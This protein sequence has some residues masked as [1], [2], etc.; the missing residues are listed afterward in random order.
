MA[1]W[2]H[3]LASAAA[4]IDLR[5]AMLSTLLIAH[6][7]VMSA[8]VVAWWLFLCAFALFNVTLWSRTALELERQKH[9]I[10]PALLAASRIQLR[11]SGVYVF[12]CAF[13][14]VLPVY[15]IPRICLFDTW[16]ADV[17]V[18]RSVAT[19]AELAFASQ[20]AVLL[21]ATASAARSMFGRTAALALVPLIAMAEVC[22]WYAVLT[23]TNLGHVFENSTWGICAALV[24]IALLA[25][26]PRCAAPRRK[27]LFLC[28]AGATYV[29]FMFV[30]DVPT[31]WARHL[32][33]QAHGR[34]YLTLAQ[35]LAEVSH[36]RVVSYRWEDWRSEI[37][38][39]TL[40]FSVA[41]WFSISLVH[42]RVPA[43]RSTAVVP[44]RPFPVRGRAQI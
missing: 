7:D 26:L 34:H 44:P 3:G 21:Y 10:S 18:G 25:I 2:G 16:L 17:V 1:C 15:D 11:L 20:W 19:L 4:C 5:G 37:V 24:V 33:D 39:M 12:G 13:R 23:T 28:I 31:Y 35:G 6:G 32:A 43:M 40:Y 30:F 42:A 36:R 41:V 29:A 14:S 38:W 8:G 22:S 27:L 9:A